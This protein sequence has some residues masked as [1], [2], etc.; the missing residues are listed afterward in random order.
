MPILVATCIMPTHIFMTVLSS[1]E[2]NMSLST[3]TTL[4]DLWK[5]TILP[6]PCYY[7]GYSSSP[8]LASSLNDYASFLMEWWSFWML[9]R[10]T[11]FFHLSHWGGFHWSIT[12]PKSCPSM[13]N[14][15]SSPWISCHK[16]GV[17]P[18]T[19]TRDLVF[20][21]TSILWWLVCLFLLLLLIHKGVSNL[22][23]LT[24]SD[25]VREMNFA[26]NWRN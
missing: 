20:C 24:W 17:S 7:Q 19:L 16:K 25:D 4:Q 15:N 23:L 21:M 18:H 26:E 1:Q 12:C 13:S 6:Y 22:I 5:Q 10:A 8:F 9:C 11:G 3:Y 14:L 2:P